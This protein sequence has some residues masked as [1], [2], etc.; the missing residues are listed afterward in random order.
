MTLLIWGMEYVNSLLEDATSVGVLH[1]EVRGDIGEGEDE[2]GVPVSERS[3]IPSKRKKSIK[4]AFL[5]ALG[6]N[7]FL[8][9]IASTLIR[10]VPE[11]PFVMHTAAVSDAEQFRHTV[12][13]K[14][15]CSV[16]LQGEKVPMNSSR[17]W[18]H[19]RREQNIMIIIFWI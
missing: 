14:A 13:N 12:R 16:I 9:Y 18:R 5:T 19:M 17:G 1:I 2:D 3:E 10:K 15:K 8:E 4:G 6:A 11:F 7:I